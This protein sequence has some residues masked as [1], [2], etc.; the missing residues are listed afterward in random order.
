MTLNEVRQK[1]KRRYLLEGR[2]QRNM[3]LYGNCDPANTDPRF[4]AYA[5]RITTVS[6]GQAHPT[7]HEWL[8]K[9]AYDQRN[10]KW[11]PKDERK[12]DPD[13]RYTQRKL[14]YLLGYIDYDHNFKD[15]PK[16]AKDFYTIEKYIDADIPNIPHSVGYR[17]LKVFEIAWDK[18]SMHCGLETISQNN[19]QEG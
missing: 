14:E 9:W 16:D 18:Y 2:R 1:N 13:T 11:I 7:F 4:E 15:F 19:P 17:L 6:N 3:G 8:S 5:K 10:T 12:V